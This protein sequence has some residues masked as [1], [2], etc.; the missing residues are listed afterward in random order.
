MTL[1]DTL[2]S[3]V[4]RLNKKDNLH[5]IV[6]RKSGE[7][8]TQCNSIRLI[9]KGSNYELLHIVISYDNNSKVN[10]VEQTD[11]YWKIAKDLLKAEN[12]ENK[13]K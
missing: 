5:F 13:Q 12:E 6:P 8:F 2:L 11:P 3:T 1:K 9:P 4:Y 10:E 7:L